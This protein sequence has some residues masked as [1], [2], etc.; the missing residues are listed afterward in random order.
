MSA[1][2]SVAQRLI[3]P[4]ILLELIT[5]FSSNLKAIGSK[6]FYSTEFTFPLVYTD[7]GHFHSVAFFYPHRKW[8]R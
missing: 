6:Y 5:H 4:Y 3:L 8:L 2:M 7:E 1:S